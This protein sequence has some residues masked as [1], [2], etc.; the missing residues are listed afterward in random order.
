MFKSLVKAIRY[1]MLVGLMLVTPIIATILIFNFL[2]HLATAWLPAT[3]FP[4]L[5]ALW[6]GYLLRLLTLLAVLAGLFIIG[7]LAR[8]IIGRRI[9]SLGDRLMTRIPLVKRIYISVQKISEAVIAQRKTLFQEVVLVEYP[10]KGIYSMA[11]VTSVL[12]AGLSAPVTTDRKPGEPCVNLFIATSPNPTSGLMIIVPRSQV[13]PL[14]M[15]VTEALTFIM[16]A[17]T[18]QTSEDQDA[19]RSLLDKLDLWLRENDL[20]QKQTGP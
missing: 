7:L 12:G 16:S 13:Y 20:P 1:N 9:Y 19:P 15:T 17:G 14:N 10:R 18:V 11:F 2:F 4:E 3:A 6:G 5:A 8:N